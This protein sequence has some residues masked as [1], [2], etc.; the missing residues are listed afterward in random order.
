M[1]L[2]EQSIIKLFFK[3]IPKFDI[4]ATLVDQK[5]FVCRF[6]FEDNIANFLSGFLKYLADLLKASNI[7]KRL[8]ALQ[9]LA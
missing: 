5:S 9:E 8:K 1:F 6:S 4:H 2:Q 7:V 3:I